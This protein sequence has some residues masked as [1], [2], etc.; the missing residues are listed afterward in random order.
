MAE[1]RAIPTTTYQSYRAKVSDG[2][3]VRVTVPENTTIEAQQFYEIDG[4]FGP[5]MQ[6]VVTEAGETSEVIL[7]IEQA[8]YETDQI[9]TTK[10]FK[11]GDKIY[12]TGGKF[13]P[14]TGAGED[15]IATNRLVGRVTQGKDQNNVIWFVQGPQV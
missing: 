11:A 9:Q 5:A 2:K 13:T 15:G 7:N 4:F 6:S 1:A 10:A 12:F 8:E 3:S 14:D